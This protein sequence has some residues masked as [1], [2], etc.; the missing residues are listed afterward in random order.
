MET[1]RGDECK[2]A[3]EIGNEN[4]DTSYVVKIVLA[5]CRLCVCIY[6]VKILQGK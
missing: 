2:R 4:V 6:I 3:S 5:V 1:K